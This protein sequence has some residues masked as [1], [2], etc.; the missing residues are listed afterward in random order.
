MSLQ[1]ND[2]ELLQPVKLSR[3]WS[4]YFISDFI[5]TFIATVMGD[6]VFFYLS[7]ENYIDLE[8]SGYLYLSL[9]VAM[10]YFIA[11]LICRDAGVNVVFTFMMALIGAKRWSMVPIIIIGQFSGGVL[12]HATMYYLINGE[13]YEKNSKLATCFGIFIPNESIDNNR[14]FVSS[15][16][17]V[18]LL[19]FS[20]FPIF[21]P[22]TGGSINRPHIHSML[23][24]AV[25][26]FAL[27]LCAMP[28][29]VQNN[30]TLWFSAYIFMWIKGFPSEVFTQHD[31]YWWVAIIGPLVGVIVAL[32]L[33]SPFTVIT[34]NEPTNWGKAYKK[35]LEPQ[36]RTQ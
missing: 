17:F 25:L 27:V 3:H 33:Y 21:S 32:F 8:E 30:P 18:A 28:L 14:C 4:R 23:L 9:G 20:L 29:G 6:G 10:S 16:I 12:G 15:I 26:I 36:D 13:Q 5:G 1:D 7:Q 2:S 22:E 31:H 35:M 24:V 19:I 11:L 34:W